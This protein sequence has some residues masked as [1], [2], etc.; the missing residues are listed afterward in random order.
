MQRM[1]VE[2]SLPKT[3]INQLTGVFKKLSPVVR[4]ARIQGTLAAT[5]TLSLP[6]KEWSATPDLQGFSVSGLGTEKL[7]TAEIH[8]RCPNAA[9][10]TFA[11][12]KW[13]NMNEMG[14]WLPRAVI[15]AED[16]HFKEHP[17]YNLDALR[18]ILAQK[19]HT[20]QHGA[21]TLTQQLAK[22]FFTG[23]A[24]TLLR[25]IE[26]LLYA[27]EM[28]NMLGKQRIFSL[29]LNTIDWGPGICGAAQAAQTYF[30]RLPARL[31]PVQ[32]AWLASIIRNPHRAWQEQFL[33]QTP[34]QK[35]LARIMSYFPR[36]VRQENSALSFTFLH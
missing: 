18:L 8:Y 12:Y 23:G 2:W 14:R 10:R 34:D 32:A 15:I 27:A 26:E 33:P 5:G 7:K 29:Y 28:E 3:R 19:N 24:R 31:T 16:A 36:K 25:K 17:G 1:T 21:S 13:L 4:Q 9:H 6:V 11:P 30:K 22:N 20:K 35:R